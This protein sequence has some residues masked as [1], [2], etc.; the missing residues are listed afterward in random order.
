MV[1]L[2]ND[3]F[4]CN[5]GQSNYRNNLPLLTKLAQQLFDCLLK[6]SDYNL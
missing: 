6:A 3:L 1:R 4:L 5:E 2:S